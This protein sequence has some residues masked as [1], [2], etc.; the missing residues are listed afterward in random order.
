VRR[1]D[2]VGGLLLLVLAVGFSAGAL[3][4]PYW[5]PTGPG[6]GF[7]P[8]WLGVALGILA[9]LLV[10][11]AGRAGTAGPAWLPAG[12]GLLRLLV[13]VGATVVLVVLLPV[14][15]MTLGAA[16]FLVG[17]LRFLEAYSWPATMAIAVGT[18]VVNYLV[19]TYWL[20]VPFPVGVL[21]F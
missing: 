7:L 8:F 21:G 17:I 16:L 12:V 5:A 10:V 4:Y 14:L 6:S 2:Q 20:R 15:G 9:L 18:A 1:A 19:F 3:Q 11:Q 13:V